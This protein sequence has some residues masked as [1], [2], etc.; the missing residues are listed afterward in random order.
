M[1]TNSRENKIE[2]K[3]CEICGLPKDLCVCEEIAREVQKNFGIL[4][5]TTP[6]G[7]MTHY[8]QKR[9]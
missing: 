2:M 4:I 7:I 3:I 6:E 9:N 8:G 1:K 5:V